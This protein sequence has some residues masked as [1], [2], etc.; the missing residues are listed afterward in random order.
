MYTTTKEK[1]KKPKP[2]IEEEP[3]KKGKS[4]SELYV[5]YE[6]IVRDDPL[7]ASQEV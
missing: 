3:V 1:K 7:H 5:D 4:I 6:K 2:V